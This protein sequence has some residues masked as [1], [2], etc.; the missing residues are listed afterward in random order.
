MSLSLIFSTKCR[1]TVTLSLSQL[2]KMCKFRV[3]MN[4][5]A[6]SQNNLSDQLR[7]DIRVTRELLQ[8]DFRAVRDQLQ[9]EVRATRDQLHEDYRDMNAR[10]DYVDFMDRN[11]QKVLY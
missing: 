9:E 2:A 4:K 3:E 5:L 7:E 10:L 1:V 11:V 6:A 8:E